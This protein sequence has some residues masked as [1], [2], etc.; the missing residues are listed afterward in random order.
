MGAAAFYRH[1]REGGLKITREETDYMRDAWISTFREMRYHMQPEKL[2]NKS[3][4]KQTYGYV[5]EDA[6][7]DDSANEG[8]QYIAKCITG[9]VRTRCTK[10]AAENC[11]F[12]SITAVGAKLAGFNMIYRGGLADRLCAFV[13]DEYLYCLWPEELDEKVPL[14]E[15][16][17]IEGMRTILPDVK[18]G[19]ETTCGVNWD[20][21]AT[22]FLKLDK[23]ASGRYIIPV[24]DLIR[25]I[26]KEDNKKTN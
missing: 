11:Q 18:V 17:M 12:Q 10:N 22:E 8:Q 23:D 25:E 16:L 14:V 3:W 26:H 7:P 21:H 9:F 2:P 5:E 15:K 1:C 4:I 20:K 19:V 13:H 24:P 6:E